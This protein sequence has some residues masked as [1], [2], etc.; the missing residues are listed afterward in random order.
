MPP[1]PPPIDLSSHRAALTRALELPNQVSIQSAIPPPAEIVAEVMG[2]NWYDV[3][4]CIQHARI[5]HAAVEN[6]PAADLLAG[7]TRITDASGDVALIAKGLA[8]SARHTRKGATDDANQQIARA[9]ALLDG[10]TGSPLFR[11]SGYMLCALAYRRSQ[12]WPMSVVANRLAL[13]AYDQLDPE[14]ADAFRPFVQLSRSFTASN[15]MGAYLSLACEAME[16]D[17]RE[18][19]NEYYTEALKVNQRL[20][21][22][23]DRVAVISGRLQLELISAMAGGPRETED[24]SRALLKELTN[25]MSPLTAVR[26]HTIRL[27]NEAIRALDEGNNGRA[28]HLAA[29]AIPIMLRDHY[30]DNRARTNGRYTLALKVRA[31]AEPACPAVAAYANELAQR[32]N[33]DRQDRVRAAALRIQ[34]EAAL[35][36]HEILTTM[37]F[38]DP[39]T[40]L[41]NRRGF[42]ERLDRLRVDSPDTAIGVLVIDVNRFKVINDTKGHLT[43]DEVLKEVAM[44]LR[45]TT[46]DHD[47]VARAGGDEF[48]VV[49]TGVDRDVARRRAELLARKVETFPWTALAEDL[50]VSVSIGCATGPSADVETLIA[51]ADEAMYE[52]KRRLRGLPV[53]SMSR[54]CG[55]PP[56]SATRH[57]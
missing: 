29:L 35:L 32:R 55:S 13:D 25:A 54:V 1:A 40:G 44:I 17:R 38:T 24:E 9:M 30:D 50:A 31:L 33:E 36:E 34:S 5:I 48:F 52:R 28:S 10:G 41:A 19:I 18:D 16:I 43:G 23:A 37:A 57:T 27:L 8:I 7:L 42:E 39:L 15:Q 6:E 11:A 47:V 56:T 14:L 3:A 4:F 45:A 53:A 21:D 51:T 2:R 49:L 46:R 22:E 26:L 20:D 12:L